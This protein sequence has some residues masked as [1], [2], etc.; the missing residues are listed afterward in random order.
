MNESATVSR[1]GLGPFQHSVMRGRPL[2]RGRRKGVRTMRPLKIAAA[3]MAAVTIGLAAA[4][5][6]NAVTGTVAVTGTNNQTITVSIADAT[7]AFGTNLAPDG[8]DSNSSD[9]VLDYQGSSGNEG[10][11][12]V[13]RAAGSGLGVTVRS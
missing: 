1:D 11:Y 13:W 4:P 3:M 5:P 2:G 8:T 6:A 12:Y 7:A 9:S 10:S